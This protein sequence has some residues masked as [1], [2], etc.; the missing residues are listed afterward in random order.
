MI[1][2]F[3]LGNP[4]KKFQFTRH[5]IGFQIADKLIQDFN[6]NPSQKDKNKEIYK[7]AIGNFNCLIVKSLTFMNLSGNTVRQITS[8]YKIDLEECWVLHDDLDLMFGKIKVKSGGSNGGHKGLESIDVLN[9]NQYNRL[10]FGIGRP[11]K[12][13]L[14]EKYVLNKFNVQ[15]K[16]T[17][18][19]AVQL[20][21]DNFYLLL[22]KKK[23]KFITKISQELNTKKKN[24]KANGF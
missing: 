20:I 14:V 1:V 16:K 18:L 17:V 6:I 12:K 5:N 8:F 10:R 4:G 11:S 15:E 24:L 23:E 21:S 19:Q 13:N 22:N 2:I 3:A 7:G 9:G